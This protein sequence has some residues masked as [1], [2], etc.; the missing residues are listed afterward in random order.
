[1]SLADGEVITTLKLSPSMVSTTERTLSVGE[2][3]VT[4][5]RDL[6]VTA[7]VSTRISVCLAAVGVVLA[8]VYTEGRT[9]SLISTPKGSF[10]LESS[11]RLEKFKTVRPLS[12]PVFYFSR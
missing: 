3:G 1:M 12:P 2:V 11:P 8:E 7:V 6:S 9:R 4:N 5:T 10:V